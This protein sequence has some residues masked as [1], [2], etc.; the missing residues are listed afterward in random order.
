MST[1]SLTNAQTKLSNTMIRSSARNWKK[2]IKSRID[3][4]IQQ[5]QSEH[6]C[7]LS[8]EELVLLALAYSSDE[9]LLVSQ[10]GEFAFTNVIFFQRQAAQFF[11][12]RSGYQ[13]QGQGIH[14]LARRVEAYVYNTY[15]FLSSRITV[16]TK[17]KLSSHVRNPCS[18]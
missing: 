11:F 1:A 14:D 5:H 8:D 10:I 15:N 16:L 13:S 3:K 18:H 7:R 2:M 6:R 9:W 12:G 4:I 17:L